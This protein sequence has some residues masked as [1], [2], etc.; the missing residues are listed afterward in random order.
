MAAL[1]EKHASQNMDGLDEAIEKVNHAWQAA[2]EDIYKAQQEQGGQTQNNPE[3][4]ANTES[5]DPNNAQ[6]AE[7]E[8]VK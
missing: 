1:K 2:S 5:N 3:S 7:F 8:E 4:N 6:E